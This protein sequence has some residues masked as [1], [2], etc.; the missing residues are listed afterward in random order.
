MHLTNWGLA[1]AQ[2][3]PTAT[4]QTDGNL[5]IAHALQAIIG[6]VTR[7]QVQGGT[8]LGLNRHASRAGLSHTAE[9]TNRVESLRYSYWL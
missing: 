5:P 9:S 3:P 2:P 7:R 4:S 8:V 6:I 1:G